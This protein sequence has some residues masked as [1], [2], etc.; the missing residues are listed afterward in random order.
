MFVP[1]ETLM[2][3]DVSPVLQLYAPPELAWKIV[4]SPI[5]VWDTQYK[6]TRFNKAFEAITGKAEEDVIGKSLE[7]LFPLIDRETSMKLIRNTH[8][9]NRMEVVEI[10]ILHVDN[11]VRTLLW[12]S[13]NI[14]SPDGMF[15][16][17]TIAQGYD[18][19]VRK[20]AE[21]EIRQL[22]VT[23]EEKVMERTMQLEN[24]NKELEAFSYSISHDLRAPLRH[25]GGFIDLLIKNNTSQLD[26]TGLTHFAAIRL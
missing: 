5:I 17:A 4:L 6:I 8:D 21:E 18:I 23:L 13:A 15:P 26:E 16:I 11:S 3:K 12:N 20:F 9:G 2:L 24:A 14:L 7:I 25:I 22:N 10:K 1:G 19:T